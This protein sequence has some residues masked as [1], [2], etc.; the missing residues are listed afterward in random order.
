[1][2]EYSMKQTL[3]YIIPCVVILV[4]VIIYALFSEFTCNQ[5]NCNNFH[6]RG[7]DYCTEHTCEENG[8]TSK[9]SS[10]L[11]VCYYH[12]E[13]NLEAD[14]EEENITLTNLQITAIRKVVD[15]Y[16]DNLISKQS[17]ILAINILNDTPETT[18]ISITYNCNVVRKDSDVNP[19]TIYVG[20][21]SDG[22]YKVESLLYDE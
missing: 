19:A 6:I 20:E 3:K 18:S 10:G 1:M 11:L 21:D 22:N 7:G 15:E 16:C 13:Q 5:K 12:F 14:S 17:S 8:C 9:K 4:P 2:Q